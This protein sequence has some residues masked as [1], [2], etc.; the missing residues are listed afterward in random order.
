MP[1]HIGLHEE[2]P[3]STEGRKAKS[4]FHRKSKE[5]HSSGLI[6]LDDSRAD[7]QWPGTWPWDD[8]GR[9]TLWLGGWKYQLQMG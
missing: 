2:V 7:P 8:L 5:E 1:P 3:V 9:G 4:S 6:N